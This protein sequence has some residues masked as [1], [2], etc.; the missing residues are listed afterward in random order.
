MSSICIFGASSTWGAWD[1]EKGGWVNRL[2]LWI[3]KQIVQQND[4]ADFYWE[5]YNLGISGDTSQD[6]LVRL[7]AEI[8]SREPGIVIIS[9]GEN[10][11]VYDKDREHPKI[12]IDQFADNLRTVI[13][14]ARKSTD[15]ILLLGLKK[16]MEN[17]VQPVSW[18]PNVNYSNESLKQYDEKLQQ[19][20]HDS[21]VSY[22]EMF[23][24][25]SDE[26]LADGLHPNEK[27]HEKIFQEVRK[28]LDQEKWL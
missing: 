3:D 6:V 25:L 16:V 9:I 1:V 21:G 17:K 24:L 26:D 28:F 10:D 2:R 19:I 13:A 12:G 14:I 4:R 18:N 7:A 22:I 8:Q 27:G 20:A 23:D 11:T 5:T 15:K